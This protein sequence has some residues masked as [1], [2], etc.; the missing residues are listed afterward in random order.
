MSPPFFW[1]DRFATDHTAT[2]HFLKNDPGSAGNNIGPMRVMSACNSAIP[3]TAS[4][5]AIDNA[6]SSAPDIEVQCHP[7]APEQ[8]KKLGAKVMA[9]NLKR[10]AGVATFIYGPRGAP[11]TIWK[12]AAGNAP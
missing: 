4:S 5:N 10:P 1:F 12:D 2:T 7:F 9:G 11:L 8:V 6:S 3:S